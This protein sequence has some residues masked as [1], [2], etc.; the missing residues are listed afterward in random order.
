MN[1]HE[2]TCAQVKVIKPAAK[3]NVYIAERTLQ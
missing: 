2:V 1:N 3:G